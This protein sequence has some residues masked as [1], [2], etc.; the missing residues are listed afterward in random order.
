MADAMTKERD[1]ADPRI[2][3]RDECVLRY[4]LDRWATE[5]T[6]KVHVVFADGEEWTFGELQ[7]MVRAKAAGLRQLGIKQGEHVAVWLPNG[8]DALLAFYAINYIGAVFVPFNT[9]YRGSL[10]QHVIANSG[11]RFLL[12]HPD[13]VPRLGEIDLAKV[14]RLVVT[15]QAQVTDAPRP[16][17]AFDSLICSFAVDSSSSLSARASKTIKLCEIAL[18]TEGRRASSGS[19]P[20]MSHMT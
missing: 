17:T 11:A 8:R 15:T 5:R 18:I 13:L 10:L 16:V 3:N 6:N 20:S 14:E 1:F 2:P 9:A 4:L 12:V 19:M 7:K